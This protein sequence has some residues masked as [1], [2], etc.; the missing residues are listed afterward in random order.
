MSDQAPNTQRRQSYLPPV[1]VPTLA[2][3]GKPVQIFAKTKK[4]VPAAR[5]RG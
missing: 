3:I 1:S 2:M 4:D 5:W